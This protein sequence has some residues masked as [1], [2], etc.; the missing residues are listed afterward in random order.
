MA[1][2]SSPTVLKKNSNRLRKPAVEKRRRD[3]INSCIKQ[4]KVI[5]EKDFHTQ[6]L[7]SRL[8]KADILEMTVRLLRQHLQDN[9]AHLL[10]GASS[11]E[12]SVPPPSSLQ[13]QEAQRGSSSTFRPKTLQENSRVW[14]PW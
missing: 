10:C 12:T 2:R 8:E 4:L 11:S 14:R 3:R 1:P 6:R 7:N 13:H 5:L 9:A